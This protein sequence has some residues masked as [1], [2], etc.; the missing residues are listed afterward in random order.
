MGIN[1]AGKARNRGADDEGQDL[2][3]AHVD[4]K[5]ACGAGIV[6]NGSQRHPEPGPAHF[7]NQKAQYNDENQ[8]QPEKLAIAHFHA[9]E[10]GFY[11]GEPQRAAGNGQVVKQRHHAK[12]E[13][14]VRRLRSFACAGER[15]FL[16]I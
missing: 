1:T 8:G 10:R 7:Y 14:P 16:S 13:T 3:A 15:G 12:A 9:K 5:G 6:I 4:A 11:N 2:V